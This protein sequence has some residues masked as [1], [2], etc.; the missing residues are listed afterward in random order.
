MSFSLL[1]QLL[2]AAAIGY[3]ASVAFGVSWNPFV[4][5]R[6][7]FSRRLW[8]YGRRIGFATFLALV[9]GVLAFGSF[10]WPL[11]EAALLAIICGSV[12]WSIAYVRMR[13]S[14]PPQRT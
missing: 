10:N 11:K 5:P 7:H 13:L 12:L 14:D 9:V 2:A 8:R 4:K 1:A 3:F 6:Q